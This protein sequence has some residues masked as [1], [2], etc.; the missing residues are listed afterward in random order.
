MLK[1]FGRKRKTKLSSNEN[2]VVE[3]ETPTTQAK[4]WSIFFQ[5]KKIADINVIDPAVPAKRKP[6]LNLK[7]V[8]P[9]ALKVRIKEE[10]SSS[11]FYNQQK[12]G[13]FGSTSV[14]EKIDV[15]I[16]EHSI[17]F[18]ASNKKAAR[19][20]ATLHRN[21]VE[22]MNANDVRNK[23]AKAFEPEQLATLQ[24]FLANKT[25]SKAVVQASDFFRVLSR[26]GYVSNTFLT[27]YQKHLQLT[28][29]NVFFLDSSL[30]ATMTHTIEKP[31]AIENIDSY[32]FLFMPVHQGGNHWAAV[33]FDPKDGSPIY[34]FNSLNNSAQP[35][36]LVQIVNDIGRVQSPQ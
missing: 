6:D 16:D 11:C 8:A 27:A 7:A 3:A 23:L 25:A 24:K 14:M 13:P 36:N 28:C 9:D 18:A 21:H 1:R 5:S 29:T 22:F 10:G 30:Y 4:K 35:N 34:Y 31:K 26:Y 33:G 17:H 32:N 12:D 20:L 2:A 19:E 15:S